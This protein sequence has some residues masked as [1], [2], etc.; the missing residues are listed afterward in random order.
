M[1]RVILQLLDFLPIIYPKFP[2]ISTKKNLWR[3]DIVNNCDAWFAKRT[4]PHASLLGFL[5]TRYI[6]RRTLLLMATRNPARKLPPGDGAKTR[7]K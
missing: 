1:F 7:G 4:G 3:L 2:T 6:D 5:L